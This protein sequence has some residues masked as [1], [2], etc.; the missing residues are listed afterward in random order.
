MDTSLIEWTPFL[1]ERLAATLPFEGKSTDAPG[2]QFAG[3]DE[4]L[5]PEIWVYCVDIFQPVMSPD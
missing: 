5:W 3:E 2:A 1:I 4:H